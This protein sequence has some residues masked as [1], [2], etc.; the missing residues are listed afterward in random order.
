MVTGSYI[1]KRVGLSKWGYV[2]TKLANRKD[3]CHSKPGFEVNN[4]VGKCTNWLD[5]DGKSTEH[6]SKISETLTL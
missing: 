3:V 6:I 2:R 4:E 1:N 5:E